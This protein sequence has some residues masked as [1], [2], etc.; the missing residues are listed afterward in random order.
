MTGFD[1][2][3]F[4]PYQLAVLAERVSQGFADLY[5]ERYGLSV[6]EWRVVAHLGQSGVVSVR[7]IH[8]CAMLGKSQ[9]SR[10][11]TKLERNGYITK[12]A[13]PE[14]GRLVSLALTEKGKSMLAELAPQAKAYERKILS[15]LDGG[16]EFRASVKRLLD[17]KQSKRLNHKTL[18]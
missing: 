10:A 1:L 3:N 18:F 13:N 7:E 8:L 9:V 14:D 15:R 5:R 6:A 2:E 16:S 17:S 11:A 12:K 4:L